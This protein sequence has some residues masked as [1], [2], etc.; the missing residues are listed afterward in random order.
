MLSFS[1]I[2]KVV[3]S[4]IVM[5]F[6]RVWVLNVVCRRVSILMLMRGLMR[7]RVMIDF[8]EKNDVND[9]VKNVFMFE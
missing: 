4:M 2:V 5:M 7:R 6:V 3:R 9:R 8:V 1:L